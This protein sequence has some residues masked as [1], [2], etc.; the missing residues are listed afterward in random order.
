[1]WQALFNRSANSSGKFSAVIA[2]SALW[3]TMI[4]QPAGHWHTLRVQRAKLSVEVG[5]LYL[6]RVQGFDG[7]LISMRPIQA[8]SGE[9]SDLVAIDACVHAVAV[10]FDLVHPVVAR[11]R[12]VYEARELRLDPC[13][14]VSHLRSR[15]CG[16]DLA[17]RCAGS[18]INRGAL[19]HRDYRG[20][21]AAPFHASRPRCDRPRAIPADHQRCCRK[22]PSDCRSRSRQ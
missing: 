14:R 12:F 22:S 15:C 2:F 9:Q 5:R 6:E 21:G 8:S 20:R 10:V 11:R 16:L 19:W 7:A 1:M 17:P 4:W 13:W 18:T 3:R